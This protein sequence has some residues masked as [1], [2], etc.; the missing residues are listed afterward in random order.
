M[1][2]IKKVSD[3]YAIAGQLPPEALQQLS[4]QGY[5]SVLNLRVPNETGWLANEQTIVE[6]AGLGYA[7]IPLQPTHLSAES[8][9]AVLSELELLPKPV[10]IHCGVG[11]RAGAIALIALATQQQLSRNAVLAKAQE[12]GINPEHPYLQVVLEDS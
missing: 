1:T 4:Q 3:V 8:Q 9:A 10:L 11:A 2:P 5:R 6:S 12:L 7:H